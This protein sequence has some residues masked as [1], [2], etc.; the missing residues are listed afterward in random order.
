MVLKLI[1]I[2]TP[3]DC[4]LCIELRFYRVIEVPEC[5][6]NFRFVGDKE[7]PSKMNMV[8]NEGLSFPRGG[9][10]LGLSPNITMDKSKMG[11]LI[12]LRGK[13][14]SVLFSLYAHITR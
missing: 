8:I 12:G 11:S 7:N 13:R 2:I 9:S 4:N 5:E 14:D 3:Q 1:T 6:G 10:D